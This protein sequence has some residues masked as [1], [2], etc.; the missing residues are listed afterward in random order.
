VNA[1]TA[2]RKYGHCRIHDASGITGGLVGSRRRTGLNRS[3]GKTPRL[4]A[5][6]VFGFE[7]RDGRKLNV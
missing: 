2:N 3:P 1:G 4:I 7:D 5:G 6:E